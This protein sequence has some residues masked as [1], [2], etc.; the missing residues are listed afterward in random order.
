[1]ILVHVFINM[2][3]NMGILPITGI[4]LPL[5]SYGGSSVMVTMMAMGFVQAVNMNRDNIN[6]QES[7]VAASRSRDFGD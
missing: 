1:M 3:M 4:P 7:L 5:I 2:G 6:N